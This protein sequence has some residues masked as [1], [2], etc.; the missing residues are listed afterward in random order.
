LI[1]VEAPI[2]TVKR[3]YWEIEAE[4]KGEKFEVIKA[5]GPFDS[6]RNFLARSLQESRQMYLGQY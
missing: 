4:L 2:P 3:R 5:I 1:W 6:P